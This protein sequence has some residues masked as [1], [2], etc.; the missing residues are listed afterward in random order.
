LSHP[1]GYL[2]LVLHAHLPYVR[3]PEYATFIEEDWLFEAITECYIPLLDV[4]ERLVRDGVPWRLS[5]SVTPTLAAMLTDPLLQERYVRHIEGLI[6]LARRETARTAADPRFNRLAHMYLAHF[7]F[8]R[9]KFEEY[10]RNLVEAFRRFQEMGY[11]EILA[12]AATHGYLPLMAPEAG[13]VRAQIDVGVEAYRRA[14]GRQ[15]AGF[16]LP[17]CGYNP[18]DDV[19]LAQAGIRYFIAETHAL[20]HACPRPRYAVFAPVYCPASG[21]AAFGRDTETSAQVWSATEGYPGDFDYRDFYRDIGY[22]LDYDYVRPWLKGEA[23]R[24][25]GIKYYRI[26]GKTSDKDVYDPDRAREKAAIH[27]GNFVFNRQRQFEHLRAHMDRPP[28]VVAPYDAELFGHWW[29]EGPQWLDYVIRKAAYDQTTFRLITPSEYLDMFPRNQVAQPSMSSWGN[30][31]YSEVWLCGANDWIYRHLHEAARRMAALADRFGA[32]GAADSDPL[33]RRAL[34]QA[35]REL[36]LAQSSDWAFIMHTGTTTEYAARRTISHVARFN[37]LYEQILAGAV[38]AAWLAE[39][40]ARDNL[41]PW[42][43][44]RVYRR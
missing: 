13:A 5:M 37:R 2:A 10:G 24:Q 25:V 35:A 17:E 16:W 23:R 42:L 43:D 30:N 29:F 36:L 7:E 41:F 3:H 32:D 8:A 22:D 1:Q 4:F 11:L 20:L 39:L 18:L 27:A 15:P 21:V 9:R 26:T 28:I 12:S 6:E 38:D 31:G 19:W 14:F 33:L 34:N 44:F 40:E